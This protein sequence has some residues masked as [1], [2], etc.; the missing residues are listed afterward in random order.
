MGNM[1]AKITGK[2]RSYDINGTLPTS[3]SHTQASTLK[4][5]RRPVELMTDEILE[6]EHHSTTDVKRNSNNIHYFDQPSIDPNAYQKASKRREPYQIEAEIDEI[7]NDTDEIKEHNIDQI[8]HL[9]E[10]I[11][12]TNDEHI[13]QFSS[14]SN[15][16]SQIIEAS[17]D[18]SPYTSRVIN[19][20]N[21]TNH[22]HHFNQADDEEGKV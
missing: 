2:Y 6:H 12:N 7:D 18:T 16:S 3:S 14:S 11:Y 4:V 8:Q 22:R 15:R 13:K 10:S 9:E 1:P 20:L 21:N 19:H 17:N 5:H